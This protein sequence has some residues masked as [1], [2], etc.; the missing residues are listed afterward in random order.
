[1]RQRATR[2]RQLFEEHKTA[3][4]PQLPQ[5]VQQQTARLLTQW[6]AALAKLISAGVDHE[7]DQC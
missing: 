4:P 3:Q 2:Q 1:M 7:Q 6:I 5:D